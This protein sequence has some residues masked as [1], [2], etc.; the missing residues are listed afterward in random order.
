MAD[1]PELN[2]WAAGIYQLETSDPVLGGPEG[3]DNLQARQLASRTKWLKDQLAKTE[4]L[5]TDRGR[6]VAVERERVAD[7][8][9][10]LLRITGELMISSEKS[11]K[12][13]TIPPT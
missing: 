6:E 1:L 7:L 5:A 12:C 10:Q 4:A 13:R 3:I 11:W 8:T 9:A 2:E